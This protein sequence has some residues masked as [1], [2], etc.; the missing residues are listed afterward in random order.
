MP[1]RC[2]SLLCFGKTGEGFGHERHQLVEADRIDALAAAKKRPHG[3]E[4]GRRLRS[5]IAAL[6]RRFHLLAALL[7][8]AP[9]RLELPERAV[10]IE[11]RV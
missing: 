10:G 1:G 4:R 3:F 11:L 6:L 5:G 7:Q 2:A 8:A 9:E